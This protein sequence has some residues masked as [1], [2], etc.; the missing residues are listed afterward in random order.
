MFRRTAAVVCLGLLAASGPAVLQTEIAYAAPT[1]AA[2]TVDT[3]TSLPA[4]GTVVTAARLRKGLWIPTTTRQAFK[5]KY[6]TTDPF[7]R[8]ATSTGTLFIPWGRA[9]RGGWPVVAWAHGTSGLGDGCAPSRIG[10]ALKWRDWRY[11]QHWMREG[12]AVVASDYVGLG[13]PG[14]MPYLDG[15]TTAHNIVDMVRAGRRFAHNRLPAT[16]R[17][18]R[19]WVTIGQSQGA[20]ASIYTARWATKYGGPRLDYRGAVGTG[21]PAYIEKLILPIGPKTPPVALTPGITSYLAYI[22]TALRYAHPELGIDGILTAEGRHWL[23]VAETAC[24]NAFEEQLAGVSVGDWFT[25]PVATLPNFEA[26]TRAYLGMPEKGFDKPFFMAHGEL[27]TDVPLAGTAAYV[28][29]LTTNGQPVTFKT[30]PTDHSG[31][32][33]ASLVDTIPFVRRLFRGLT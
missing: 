10:P 31:T 18:A 22:F 25:Q 6:V 12:Y 8:R 19:K 7:G 15:R 3:T 5:L 11:L 14:L 28:G 9:P 16:Q 21:T 32:M 29:V 4:P 30:Y 1:T 20:G 24:V 2:S 33:A 17:L 27:D 13:T 26:T 23:D